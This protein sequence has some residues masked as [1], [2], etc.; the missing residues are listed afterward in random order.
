M[1]RRSPQVKA[2]L[3][4]LTAGCT[5]GLAIMRHTGLKS[6]TVYPILRRME[7]AGWVSGKRQECATEPGRPARRTY[8]LTA[9][10]P[11]AR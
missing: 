11:I 10:A 3:A 7:S 5:Y 6:G 8:E 9:K 4:A 2:V 1:V